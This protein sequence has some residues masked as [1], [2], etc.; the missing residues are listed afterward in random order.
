MTTSHYT[1]VMEEDVKDNSRSTTDIKRRHCMPSTTM[2]CYA[3]IHTILAK[4]HYRATL[5]SARKK[6]TLQIQIVI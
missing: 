1:T 3:T 6:V 5:S 4:Q 2:A